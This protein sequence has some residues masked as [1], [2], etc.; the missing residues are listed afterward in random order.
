MKKWITPI[1][2]IVMSVSAAALLVACDDG[3]THTFS[4][5]WTSDATH[6]WHVATCEHTDQIADKAAHDFGT[7]GKCT[8]C[9]KEKEA[10]A[11]AYTVTADV[12]TS[13]IEALGS[14][15]NVEIVSKTVQG[16]VTYYTSV[17]IDGNVMRNLIYNG[18]TFEGETICVTETDGTY[19]FYQRDTID[20]AFQKETMDDIGFVQAN[21]F[22]L[23]EFALKVK[24]EFDSATFDEQSH[25]YKLTVASGVIM[26]A[27]V[28]N[29]AFELS[30]E[31]GLLVA[32][33]YD[34][35]IVYPDGSGSADYV[36]ELGK[37]GKVVITVPQV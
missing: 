34:C 29:I 3:H 2:A 35:H 22:D 20:G 18:E 15:T 11:S 5:A 28:D 37:F 23:V 30:F 24:N 14:L 27:P 36:V 31:N 4:P 32:V 12:W 33:K 7:D 6:H 19:T 8:V 9:L 16:N 26:G 13:Q 1:L 10:E 25:S 21:T 17:E